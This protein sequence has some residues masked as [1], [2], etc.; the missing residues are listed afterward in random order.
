[1]MVRKKGVISI[2]IVLA[3]ISLAVYILA[4]KGPTA[5]EQF[6]KCIAEKAILYT[7]TGCFACVKQEELFGV[8]NQYLKIVNCKIE[9]QECINNEIMQTPT[10]IIGNEKKIGYKTLEE[11]S[12]LT[13]CE[14]KN[15]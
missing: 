10:W 11:L 3:I 13:G 8:N 12:E 5:D 1:M 4:N 2:I 15:G 7:Q 14:I 9:A 6:A